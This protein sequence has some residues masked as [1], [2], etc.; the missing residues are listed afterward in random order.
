MK[1]RSRRLF[2]LLLCLCLC[3]SLFPAAWAAGGSWVKNSD[4]SWSYKVNGEY[5]T[6]IQEIDG[7]R[8]YFDPFTKVMLD[9]DGE[10]LGGDDGMIIAAAG[11]KLIQ[12]GWG[13]VKSE[14]PVVGSGIFY[15]KDYHAL[16]GLQEIDGKL[17]FFHETYGYLRVSTTVEVDGKRYRA[18]A[19]GVLT[20]LETGD[21]WHTVEG[22]TY[23]Y[24]NGEPVTSKVLEIE[25]KLYFFDQDGVMAKG[26]R[27]N[28]FGPM[29]VDGG[30]YCAR[31]DG[32]LLRSEWYLESGNRYYYGD[33]GRMYIGLERV[34]D[35]VYYFDENGVLFTGG[36][37]SLEGSTYYADGDGLLTELQEGWNELQGDTI[38]LSGGE[39]LRGE[40]YEI[41]GKLYAFDGSGKLVRSAMTS[42]FGDYYVTD[43]D[44]VIQKQAWYTDEEGRSFYFGKDGTALR[45]L[46]TIGGKQYIFASEGLPEMLKNQTVELSGKKYVLGE[47]GQVLQNG[48]VEA[49][50]KRRY[51]KDGEFLTGLQSIDGKQ[52]LF[53]ED[54]YLICKAMT[55]V[56]GAYYLSGEDGA[57]QSELLYT[58]EDGRSFYFGSD[59]KAQRGL[60]TVDGKQYIFASQG[61][62]EMLKDQ[63]VSLDGKT[64]HVDENG[65]AE[66]LPQ[67]PVITAQPRSLSVKEGGTAVFSLTA[68]GEELHYQWYSRPAGSEEWTPCGEDSAQLRVTAGE[69]TDGSVYRCEVRN[70][71]GSVRSDE[72]TL[73]VQF[74]EPTTG[75]VTED[76]KK[77]YYD[78]NGRML[79]AQ[80][81][82]LNGS[83]YYFGE[84]GALVTD[85]WLTDEGETCYVNSRGVKVLNDWVDSDGK[86]YYMDGKGRKVTGRQTIRGESYLFGE[87]GAL[88]AA[89]WM[90]DNGKWYYLN[91]GG[92]VLKSRWLQLEGKW[93]FL[94]AD[95]AR[96]ESQ[97]LKDG[98]KW[99]YFESDGVMAADKQLLIDGKNYFFD[100]SGAMQTGKWAQ[101]GGSWYYVTASGA[102]STG[103]QK[104]GSV[105]YWFDSSGV[106]ATG[107]RQIDGK[108]YCFQ[109]SGAMMSGKWAQQG[110]DWYYLGS[111]GAAVTG[112]QKIGG[113]WYWFDG[114][115]VMAT[116][117]RSI[118]GA[119]YCFKVSGAMMSS[120]WVQDG[121]SWYYVTG[122]GAA[123]TGWLKLS[124]KW[125]WFEADGVMIADTSR[126]IGGKVYEFN[127]SGVCTNP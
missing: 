122:S 55:E 3:A 53:G 120:Q 33:D 59:C 107:W 10:Y 40:P 45:G 54:S 21:G 72:V 123:A 62:P 83:S 7:A 2:A 28:T 82:R 94:G 49:D 17:Y 61:L 116:G 39:P 47:D 109:S 110:S 31:E 90:Q 35:G 26:G 44:G 43:A 15:M 89:G 11:G 126:E 100:A 74:K 114:S 60:Q 29:T 42:F 20:P 99:Y 34:D 75:W 51:L 38:Y 71:V 88:V 93:Y 16:R 8:Y 12:S 119:T 41:D 73:T 124:G 14:G 18:N 79:T 108:L 23:Y 48:W 4:G 101:V 30:W 102:V 106:M 97:W 86:R 104:I 85:S 103:W 64:Y 36:Y 112:W 27:F 81:L 111:S 76:G 46:Q 91:N 25:G 125:Y 57:L 77:Y 98:S 67:A 22:K 115:G 84:D 50:G 19:E 52:Y 6:G 13:K 95:G 78:E 118:G 113:S 24:Q 105:W 87:D 58:D 37:I 56:D 80:W 92:N 5:V 65:V 1:K 68:E 127:A 32:S 66:L 69:E 63:D 117:V 9:D 121:G 70:S 96:L